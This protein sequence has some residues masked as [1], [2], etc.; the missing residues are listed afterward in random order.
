MFTG[1]IECLAEVLSVQESGSNRVFRLRAEIAPEFRV[2]ESVAHNGVCLTVEDVRLAEQTYRVTAIEETLQRSNL[3]R[4]QAGDRVNLERALPAGARLD[5]HFVQGHVDARGS[6]IRIEEHSGSWEFFIR[7]APEF[8]P[9]VVPKG[10]VA[11]N[12]IS[13]TI[14]SSEPERN[15]ISVAI[16]PHTWGRTDISTWKVGSEINIEFDV[17]GKYVQKIMRYGDGSPG[18]SGG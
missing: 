10:S 4:L 3:G 13:L 18:G 7:Y 9:L 15:Q 14:A 8:E 1:I 5:G 11:L 12:G 17:L 2:D 16:I 6:V